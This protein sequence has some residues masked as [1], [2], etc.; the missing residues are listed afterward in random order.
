M[1]RRHRLRREHTA[2]LPFINVLLALCGVVALF[3]LA[4]RAPRAIGMVSVGRDAFRSRMS[5]CVTV[6]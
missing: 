3:V 6:P 2:S 4:S 5:T 1:F